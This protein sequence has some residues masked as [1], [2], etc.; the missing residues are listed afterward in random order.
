MSRISVDVGLFLNTSCVRIIYGVCVYYGCICTTSVARH[1]IMTCH[2]KIGVDMH[3]HTVVF[4]PS[5]DMSFINKMFTPFHTLWYKYSRIM[6]TAETSDPTA[7]SSKVL[8]NTRLARVP[9]KTT[10]TL[11]NIR[12]TYTTGTTIS[13][14]L[15]RLEQGAPEPYTCIT[16]RMMQG[17]AC[18]VGVVHVPD[19]ALR[20]AV[21]MN[22][23]HRRTREEQARQKLLNVTLSENA[24]HVISKPEDDGD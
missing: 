2:V 17:T 8:A 5:V 4:V 24:N 6:M 9:K 22:K 7:E 10:H 14:H 20:L 15:G 12:F 1:Q 11:L 23:Q 18:D 16:P 21:H 3:V 19:E 13:P